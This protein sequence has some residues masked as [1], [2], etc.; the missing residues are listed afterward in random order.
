M[1]KEKLRDIAYGAFVIVLGIL[2]LV[3]GA[4]TA[5]NTYIGVVSII[6][7]LLLLGFGIYSVAK[8]NIIPATFVIM[9]SVLIVTAIALFAEKLSFAVLI[10]LFVFIIM[11]IGVGF[12][13]VGIF[14][15]AKVNKLLGI[16][17]I[18]VGA[19]C[20]LLTALYLGVN[21]FRTAFWYVAGALIIVYGVF[22]IIAT[23]VN[24]KP[25]R[26]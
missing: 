2:V 25:V 5:V 14:T 13:V 6:A 4:G 11:G 10:D 3:C 9:G 1:S 20:I 21:D 19:F 16:I 24:K 26:K 15:L 22:V 18:C 7:G 17:Q 12:V 8:N 23:L